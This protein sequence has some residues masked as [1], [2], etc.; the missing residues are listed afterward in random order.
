[1]K[2]YIVYEL[3]RVLFLSKTEIDKNGNNYYT[4]YTSLSSVSHLTNFN[5]NNMHTCG[6]N[7]LTTCMHTILYETDDP[8]V[9]TELITTIIAVYNIT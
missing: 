3:G 6:K 7:I 1:M 5:I 2:K 4:T 8:I 9:D